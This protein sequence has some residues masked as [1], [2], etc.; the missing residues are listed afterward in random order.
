MPQAAALKP[1][2]LEIAQPPAA[3]TARWRKNHHRQPR[4]AARPFRAGIDTDRT[5]RRLRARSNGTATAGR[6]RK[7]AAF[8]CAEAIANNYGI[9]FD[10]FL[11]ERKSLL[12]PGRA[13]DF[14]FAR[15]LRAGLTVSTTRRARPA[16]AIH[17]KM[18]LRKFF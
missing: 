2:P 8:A 12:I 5:V 16:I 11:D 4:I 17:L 3:R 1:G 14:R 15:R 6:E 9:I 10:A 18:G 7:R 13:S